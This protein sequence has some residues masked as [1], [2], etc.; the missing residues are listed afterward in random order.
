MYLATDEDERWCDELSVFDK[1]VFQLI[2]ERSAEGEKSQP[3]GSGEGK[4][5]AARRG[6]KQTLGEGN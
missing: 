5:E 6:V 3:E 2:G 1:C 4:N